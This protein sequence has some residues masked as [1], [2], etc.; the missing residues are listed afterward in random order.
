MNTDLSKL[1]MGLLGRLLAF[2]AVLTLLP[3]SDEGTRLRE[4]GLEDGDLTEEDDLPE[5]MESISLGMGE[6]GLLLVLLGLDSLPLDPETWAGDIGTGASTE[7]W[8]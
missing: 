8:D 6:L 1:G 3:C 5:N 7:F 2:S 4:A